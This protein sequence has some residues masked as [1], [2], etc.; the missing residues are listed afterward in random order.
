MSKNCRVYIS[1][2][3][4][5]TFRLKD[6]NETIEMFGEDYLDDYGYDIPETKLIE[7]KALKQKWNDMQVYLRDLMNDQDKNR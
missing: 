6:S 4:I 1:Y 5:S 3:D 2:D 7:Y